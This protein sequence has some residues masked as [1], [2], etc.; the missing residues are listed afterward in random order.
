MIPS[1]HLR[2]VLLTFVGIA[3]AFQASA[4]NSDELPRRAYLGVQVGALTEDQ[5]TQ[6]DYGL[7]ILNVFPGSTAAA[8]DLQPGQIILEANG[9]ALQ[10][11]GDLPEL[12]AGFPSG[13]EV[14]FLI[15]ENSEERLE[16]R[17]IDATLRG[18]PIEQYPGATLSYNS[19]ETSVGVQRTIL[20]T[21]DAND[22]PPVVYVLQG[23]DCSSV[24]MALNAGNSMAL[25]IERLNASGFAT[26]RVEKS[27]RGDSVGQ[28]C[29]EIGF[30]A[31]TA[32]F[33]AGLDALKQVEDIDSDQIYL[34]GISLGGIWAPILAEHAQVAGIISFGTIAKTWPEYMA[35]NWRRQWSL[36]DKSLSAQD[37]DLKLATEFW[38]QLI[39]EELSPQEIFDTYS[40]VSG[41]APAVGYVEEGQI[42]FGRHFSFVQELAQIN[43]MDYWESVNVPTLVVWGRGDYVASEEDQQLIVEM[44]G[45]NEVPV[46]I[47]YLDVDHYWREAADFATAYQGLRSQERPPISDEVYAAI[48][49]WLVTTG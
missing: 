16:E 47:Q 15:L 32:G 17:L 25:L 14:E 1:I 19:I 30:E 10:N 41:L 33:L 44:L 27:G 48:I 5:L 29:S 24:D 2:S 13:A 20:T 38:Y 45:S 23:F 9:Q 39:H 43:V 12:L 28:A 36:A 34:L 3:F 35:D 11:V 7:N 6:T 26:F 18:F 49:E 22:R 42:L 4:Q 8:Y 37:R 21:P 46:D 31:E 40:H